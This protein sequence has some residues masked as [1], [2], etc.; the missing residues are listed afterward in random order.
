MNA[1]MLQSIQASRQNA[2]A[3][4]N[5]IAGSASSGSSGG[6]N[7]HDYN[8]QLQT[9]TVCDDLGR[10]QSVDADISNWWSDCSGTFHPGSD[11]GGPPPASQSACWA[12]GH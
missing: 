4:S 1:A 9:K 11:S 12:K 5:A 3:N 2:A 10:C 6:G 8:A 7:G